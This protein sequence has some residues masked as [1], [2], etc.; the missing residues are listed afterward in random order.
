MMSDN[1][2]AYEKANAIQQRDK[3]GITA[4]IKQSNE[5]QERIRKLFNQIE[6]Q[7]S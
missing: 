4:N 2:L 6:E 1:S 3:Y 5:T 7:T